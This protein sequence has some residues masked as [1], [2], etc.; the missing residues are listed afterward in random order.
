MLQWI[1]NLD[2]RL[3]DGLRGLL[4]C[5]LLDALMPLITHLGDAGAIW[6]LCGMAL[7]A[8]KK[9]RKNGLWLLCG[10]A[11][12]VLIGNVA[13]KNWVARPRP[14][15]LDPNVPLLIDLPKDYSFPSGHTLASVI[16]A[17]ALTRANRKF[18]WI[19]MPLA[20]LIALS[21][22]YLFVHFPSDVLASVALGLAID[23]GVNAL[24]RRI[25]K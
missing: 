10:L 19:A 21:R 9:Y 11:I 1:Q 15:W 3:L 6:I 7:L 16:A 13:L 25:H 18:G 14:C 17:A 12:G 23:R 8:S 5:S 20:A 24:A 2:W 22:L 4:S